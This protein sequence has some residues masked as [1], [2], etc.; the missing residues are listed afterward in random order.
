ML[1]GEGLKKLSYR[2]IREKTGVLLM[3]LTVRR[4]TS[5]ARDQFNLTE[6]DCRSAEGKNFFKKNHTLFLLP[7]TYKPKLLVATFFHPCHH[8]PQPSHFERENSPK[9][10][11]CSAPDLNKRTTCAIWHLIS[12][13]PTR[14]TIIQRFW[15]LRE[16]VCSICPTVSC[17]GHHL[18]PTPTP[19]RQMQ[20]C[21]RLP[22][23]THSRRGNRSQ[24]RALMFG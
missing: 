21:S 1:V 2:W 6:T 12:F 4:Y 3:K 23:P 9:T 17:L 24:S 20:V 14:E 22:S 16:E 11:V 13:P 5:R 15:A 7:L 8:H 18:L 10:R 19:L